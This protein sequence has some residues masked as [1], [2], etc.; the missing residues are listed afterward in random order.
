MA[1]SLTKVMNNVWM[2]QRKNGTCTYY[3]RMMNPRTGKNEQRPAVPPKGSENGRKLTMFLNDEVSKMKRELAGGLSQSTV[4]TPFNDYFEGPFKSSFTGRGKTWD[5]YEGLYRRHIREW[6]GNLKLGDINKQILSDFFKYLDN[7]KH[8][9]HST[10]NAIYRLLHSVLNNAVYDDILLKNP[11][12]PRGV[13]IKAVE[14]KTRAMRPEELE[15]LVR[16]LENEDLMWRTFYMLTISTG[17]RRG[18]MVGLMWEDV[19]LFSEYPCI[20][21]NHSVEYIPKKGVTVVEPKTPQSKRTVYI[22]GLVQDL[23]L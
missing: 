10:Y 8:V 3:I 16:C 13:K 7:E 18:E 12:S 1:G 23:L 20:T 11:L 19:D 17:C 22:P 15:E 9:G 21:V 4:R 2:Y 14:S 6:M 5:G